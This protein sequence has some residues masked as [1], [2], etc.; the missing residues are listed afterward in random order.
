MPAPV[1]ITME[2][3]VEFMAAMIARIDRLLRTDRAIIPRANTPEMACV[4]ATFN[5]AI[6]FSY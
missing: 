5:T 2:P 1:R 6:R 3:M 4:G